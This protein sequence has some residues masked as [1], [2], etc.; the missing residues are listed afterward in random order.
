[1]RI[2]SLHPK[3]LDRQGLTACWR[4]TLLAQAVLADRTR[5]YRSHPQ[6][7]RFRAHDDPLGAVCWYLHGIADEADAGGYRYDRARINRPTFP[8]ALIPVTT[9]QVDREWWWLRTKL[10]ARSPDLLRQW[11]EL[12]RPEPHPSFE[13]VDGPVAPWERVEE[14]ATPAP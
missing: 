14:P 6:L 7:E 8:V 9:G 4:E 2:W 13:V 5:G 11:A 1:M 10:A 12:C 3:H